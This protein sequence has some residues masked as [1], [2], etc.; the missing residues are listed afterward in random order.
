MKIID[1]G[2]LPDDRLFRLE[3]IDKGLRNTPTVRWFMV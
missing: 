3:D 2:E 1:E